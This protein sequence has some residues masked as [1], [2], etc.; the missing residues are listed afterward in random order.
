MNDAQMAAGALRAVFPSPQLFLLLSS[1]FSSACLRLS[2]TLYPDPADM[3]CVPSPP[4]SPLRSNSR[5]DARGG[6]DARLR[7]DSVDVCGSR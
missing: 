4:P 5:D 2:D 6:R 3:P 7:L 1:S